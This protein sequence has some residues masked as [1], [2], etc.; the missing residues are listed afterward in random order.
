MLLLKKE[1]ERGS[2]FIAY[3]EDLRDVCIVRLRGE[4]FNENLTFS[5]NLM[6]RKYYQN[7]HMKW[8]QRL[9]TEMR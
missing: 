9:M 8:M 6:T 3:K 7:K 2:I 1:Q 5:E 4:R